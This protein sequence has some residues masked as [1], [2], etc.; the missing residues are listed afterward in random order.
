MPTQFLMLPPQNDKTREWGARLA[1]ELPELEVIVAEDMGARRTGDRDGR[2]RVWHDPAGIAA[3]ARGGSD[4]CKR[5]KP[6]RPPA[7]TIPS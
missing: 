1:A 5:R 2:K 4:G 3:D 6:R 7:T